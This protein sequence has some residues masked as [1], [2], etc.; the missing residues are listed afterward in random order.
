MRFL[1]IPVLVLLS[2]SIAR[3]QPA[4]GPPTAKELIDKFRKDV[5]ADANPAATPYVL[6]YR[7]EKFMYA[8]TAGKLQAESFDF[9]STLTGF[10]DN[11]QKMRFQ[12]EMK[13]GVVPLRIIEVVDGDSGWYQINDS[14]AVAMSKA[15]VEGRKQREKQ[16]DVFLGMESFD[17]DK[18]Q[19]STPKSVNMHGHEAW[20][21]D[22]K[23]KGSEPL[24]LTFAK[25][26]GLL[27][28]LKTKAVDFD[29]LPG[30]KPTIESFTR[31]FTF[32]GWKKFGNR[33]VPGHCAAFRDNVLWRHMEPVSVAFPKTID[34]KLFAMPK[35]K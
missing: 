28:S 17:P 13:I 5:G 23:T 27:V 18:W 15:Q 29:L 33:M 10:T 11:P 22:A 19:F 25:Q 16:I 32:Y 14:D 21:V 35:A 7:G 2:C 12:L 4:S 8:V 6:K 9:E 20:E 24:T 1:A 3:G 26:S 34:E 31:E 30:G